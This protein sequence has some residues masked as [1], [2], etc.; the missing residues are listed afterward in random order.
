MAGRPCANRFL[1]TGWS[2]LLAA[3]SAG[4]GNLGIASLDAS[5]H[6]ALEALGAT[7]S[8][9][10]PASARLDGEVG[11]TS[12]W[13]AELL[14]AI[15]D[16]AFERGDHA[17]VV[18][19]FRPL[20]SVSERAR[21]LMA[22]PDGP[23]A[24]AII[25][26]R[27]ADSL[28]SLRAFS[29]AARWY[30][31]LLEIVQRWN[32]G[33]W[34]A[35]IPD[36]SYLHERLG[37]IHF[38]EL[39][40]TAAATA[41]R[42]A[43]A[44]REQASSAYKAGAFLVGEEVE[45]R[46]QRRGPASRSR[47]E[48]DNWRSGHVILRHSTGLADA[49]MSRGGG[50]WGEQGMEEKFCYV[51]G[52]TGLLSIPAGSLCVIGMEGGARWVEW[53]LPSELFP[54]DIAQARLRRLPLQCKLAN[55]EEKVKL[56][57]GSGSGNYMRLLMPLPL[58][59][60][61]DSHGPGSITESSATTA[62][63]DRCSRT[64]DSP[65][66]AHSHGHCAA[67]AAFQ[68]AALQ[69]LVAAP[70]VDPSKMFEEHGVIAFPGA[71]SRGMCTAMADYLL[72]WRSL[73]STRSLEVPSHFRNHSTYFVK[74]NV[75]RDHFTLLL[76]EGPIGGPTVRDFLRALLAPSQQGTNSSNALPAALASAIF[77]NESVL[78]ELAAFVTHPGAEAQALHADVREERSANSEEPASVTM[79]V[80]LNDVSPHQGGLMAWPGSHRGLR[81]ANPAVLAWAQRSAAFASAGGNPA[82]FLGVEMAPLPAGSVVAYHSQLWHRG[83][84]NDLETPRVVLYVSLLS[85]GSAERM[86]AALDAPSGGHHLA[87]APQ[88]KAR[89][90]RLV[91]LL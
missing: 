59:N 28:L 17:T 52:A 18:A 49:G 46:E 31:G 25:A 76:E 89:R 60:A 62:E 19:L 43:L 78:W 79:Q 40:W 32:P 50:D 33:Q 2:L 69:E 1:P 14:R 6:D 24:A 68:K 34:P 74:S 44:A 87:L 70:Q 15:G 48:F 65:D 88:Y 85:G 83:G 13:A 51:Q 8:S 20:L 57:N 58:R 30:V 7:L 26:S 80:L 21:S 4:A 55:T 75:D 71:F 64:S 22:M 90:K 72:Q 36:V 91:D 63:S 54:S 10:Q 41:F 61:W 67:Q 37:D 42:R 81:A 27:L 39:R 5:I 82:E 84:H 86:R 53:I 38:K 35:T 23:A 12:G 45:V 29:Q 9:Q 11:E 47:E 77:S 3:R 56:F 16:R 66:E 73:R